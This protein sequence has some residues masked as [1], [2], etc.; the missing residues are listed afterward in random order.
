[1]GAF[2]KVDL[3]P[4]ETTNVSVVIDPRLLAMYDSKSKT[5]TIKKGE[6]QVMLATS[7]E[8]IV[9]T[10]KV[11]LPKKILDVKGK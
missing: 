4:G 1:L 5:W 2:K 3:K 9:S 7:S 8:H 6:Y 10:V 11:R